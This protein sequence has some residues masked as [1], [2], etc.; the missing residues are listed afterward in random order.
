MTFLVSINAKIW[1]KLFVI[2]CL[3]NWVEIAVDAFWNYIGWKIPFLK[4]GMIIAWNE[5][6]LWLHLWLIR[7]TF[8]FKLYH[9]I[10]N[11]FYTL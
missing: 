6:V 10:N 3:L 7:Y 4:L 1:E 9:K 2:V 11:K 8:F 5:W